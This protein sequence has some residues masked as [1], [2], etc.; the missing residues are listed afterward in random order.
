MY[1]NPSSQTYYIAIHGKSYAAMQLVNN[2]LDI[3][4][5]DCT[6]AAKTFLKSISQLSDKHCEWSN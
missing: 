1:V 4:C 2:Q 3:Q 5:N 6:E